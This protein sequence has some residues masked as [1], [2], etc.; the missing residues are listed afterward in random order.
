[1]QGM[2][3][4]KNQA[5]AYQQIVAGK[6]YWCTGYTSTISYI[7]CPVKKNYSIFA[8]KAPS[9]KYAVFLL[10]ALLTLH[11]AR[12]QNQTLVF[13]G[14]YTDEKPDKGI[15]VYSLD[16]KTGELKKTGHGENLINPS[17][18]TLSPTG[19]F[20]YACTDTRQATAGSITS[21]RIDSLHGSLTLINK[22]PSGGANPV[23][24]AVDNTGRF[25]INGNYT[26]GSV[27][28]RTTDNQGAVQP[29][30]QTIP[31]KDSSINKARQEQ[32]HIHSTVFSPSFDYVFS[33]D[34]GADKIRVFRFNAGEEKP[35][36]EVDSLT[37][38]T[39]PGSGPRHLVFHPN[40]KFAYCTEEM[41]GMVSV[42]SYASG[43]LRRIQRA[44]SY[45]KPAEQ[46]STA[47]L[48]VSPDGLFL[49]ASNRI[50]NTLSI[51]SI[52]ID[53]TLILTGHQETGGDVPRNFS[54]DPSGHFILVANQSSNNIVV[55]RRDAKTGLLKRTG[56]PVTV[57]SPSCIQIRTYGR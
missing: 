12:A 6:L 13:I 26:G 18:L 40:K 27:A 56:K 23:Y 11:T 39:E 17:F 49:Y 54:I 36:A 53:G 50:E 8:V 43:K 46:Y 52:R 25:T 19:Q 37:V 24:I 14:T 16:S 38:H 35:L 57:P 5:S 33:P 22:Q 2:N 7:T 31:F 15:Y 55:F 21:F 42:Y 47:D 41:G 28:V 32:S 34:L 29:F 45:T 20:L 44:F 48:H 4:R 30:A 9:M 1:M 10:L 51:F 3:G